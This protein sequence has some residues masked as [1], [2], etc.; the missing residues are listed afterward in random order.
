MKYILFLLIAFVS[1]TVRGQVTV[2]TSI[3][4]DLLKAPASPAFNILGIATSDIDRPTDVTSFALSLQDATN[5]FTAIPKSY[6]I[7]VAPFLLGQRKFTLSEFNSN[8][9]AFRQSFLISAGFTHKGPEGKEDVDS[10]KTTRLGVGI[11]FSI[12]RPE[13]SGNTRKSY[14]TLIEAQKKLLQHYR[15]FENQHTD[16]Q[17][18]LEKRAERKKLNDK[19][20]KTSDDEARIKILA[21]EI[22]AL[23]VNINEDVNEKLA[24][25]STAFEMAK[26]ASNELKD[27]RKGA[28]IDFNSGL[29]FDFP[30]K[31]L[32]NGKVYRGG[33]WLTGGYENG[34]K[35]VTALFI[36]R[37]LYNPE[38]IFADPNGVFIKGDDFSTFD[39][40]A[41]LLLNALK[42]RFVF[43]GEAIYRSVLGN[44]VVE[45]SWRLVLNTEYD[46]GFNK[47]LTFSFGRDFDGTISKGGNLIAA[48]NLI[49]G[50]GSERSG[51]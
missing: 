17:L 7:Q 8:E 21:D 30:S 50:F 41:K 36:A 18:L 4:L 48:L 2:D 44:S 13:W 40:G 25:S 46:V 38:N 29:A 49:M 45:P 27:E 39:S 20:E 3:K 11:K 23:T 22:R 26:K 10:L 9:H 35:G 31:R 37:Y 47:K 33:A 16:Y 24:T 32:G 51:Q 5:N 19:E 14:N 43:S 28:F 42:S 12:L 6:A 34:N 15:E 1:V